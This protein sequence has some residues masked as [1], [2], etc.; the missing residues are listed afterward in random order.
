MQRCW[1]INTVFALLIA[2]FW[3]IGTEAGVDVEEMFVSL[4]RRL[5]ANLIASQLL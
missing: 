5:R 2:G 1:N 3:S 4:E